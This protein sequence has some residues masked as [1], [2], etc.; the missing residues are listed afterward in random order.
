MIKQSRVRF[1][2]APIK[3]RRSTFWYRSEPHLSRN[4]SGEVRFERA[5]EPRLNGRGYIPAAH[6]Q[7]HKGIDWNATGSLD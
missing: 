7:G 2:A 4:S 3:A 1:V 5:P 6:A